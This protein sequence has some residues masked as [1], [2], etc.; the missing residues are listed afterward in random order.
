M[1]VPC[2]GINSGSTFWKTLEKWDTYWTETR[3]ESW[4]WC[5]ED[6]NDACVCYRNSGVL[7]VSYCLILVLSLFFFFR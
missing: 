7:E 4:I 6:S 1:R 2:L 3:H 5:R